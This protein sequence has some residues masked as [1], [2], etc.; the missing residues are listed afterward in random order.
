MRRLRAV[1]RL[2]RG[3]LHV[4]HGAAICAFVFP[5]VDEAARS[6]RVARWSARLLRV[7]GV[8]VDARG[9]PAPG[10]VLLVAN[11][12]SWLDVLVIDAS[13]PARF[14]AKADLRRWPLLGTMAARGGTLFIERRH[15]RDALRVVHRVAEA[16]RA[17]QRVA[18]FPEGTTG[19]GRALLPFHANLVQA[20]VV[21]AT[22]LQPV[23]LRY[24]DAAARVSAAAAYV[25]SLSLARSAWRIACADRLVAHVG[26]LAPLPTEGGDR[27]VLAMAAHAAVG[28][29]LAGLADIALA[30]A[31]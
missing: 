6:R 2:A 20:A 15:K 7:L 22:P 19:D 1:W 26:Y 17:G 21:T 9:T 28:D 12:V 8:G 16:L 18:V 27:R 30:A 11:H 31:A 24:G 3:A 23:A 25:G 4:A 14:V 5:F 13:L 29:E 10:P